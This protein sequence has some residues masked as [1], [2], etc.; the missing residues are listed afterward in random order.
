MALSG[1]PAGVF[2]IAGVVQLFYQFWPHTRM[3]G[4]MG[5]LD[6]WVQTPSNHRVHHAQNDISLDRNYVGVY[7]LWDRLFGTYKD[8]TEF[9][10]RCGFPAGAEEKLGAMLAFEDVHREESA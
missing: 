3:I 9:S 10:D 7:T 5:L 6:W 1:S 8:T 2:A 4:R